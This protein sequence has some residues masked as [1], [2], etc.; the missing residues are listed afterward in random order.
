M[1]Y[2]AVS[3]FEAWQLGL[4]HGIQRERRLAPLA[5]VQPRYNLLNRSY[6]RD[7]LPLATALGTGVVLYNPLGAG[8]L[9]GKYKRGEEPPE[10]SRFAA[11]DLGRLYR[12]CYWSDPMFDAADEVAAVARELGMTPAQVAVG[13]LLAQP[14]VTSPIV[15]A[16]RPEQLHDVA[17]ALERPLPETAVRS[18]S[19][20]T[21]GFR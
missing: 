10:G 12:G 20:A 3:N 13:W 1:L 9:T 11:G 16:T 4:A 5:A 6:E 19:D 7:L 8:V 17:G 18:L 15:G 14:P 2:P 21:L